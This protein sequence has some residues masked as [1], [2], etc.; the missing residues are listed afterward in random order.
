[1]FHKTGEYEVR[2]IWDVLALFLSMM[3]FRK[4]EPYI[5]ILKRKGFFLGSVLLFYTDC[6]LLQRKFEI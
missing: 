1:M 2:S 6:I 5:D 4:V 3:G